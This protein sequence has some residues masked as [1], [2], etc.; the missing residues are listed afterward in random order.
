MRKVQY[1][2]L[3]TLPAV[4][5]IVVVLVFPLFYSLGTSLTRYMLNRPDLRDFYWFNNY[6]EVLL[7]P[8]IYS[9]LWTTI[10]F[11]IGALTVEL[12]LGYML[13]SS[14]TKALKCRN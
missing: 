7:D 5:A 13:A 10:K 9:T 8:R 6:R 1:K 2:H 4:I 14:L 12:I 11:T 3:L